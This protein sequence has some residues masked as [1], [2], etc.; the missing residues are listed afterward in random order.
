MRFKKGS[1]E[2][3]AFMAKL[4]NARKKKAA[5][6]KAVK[7]ATPKKAAPK[8]KPATKKAR[9]HKDTKSHNVRISVVS[10]IGSIKADLTRKLLN[11]QSHLAQLM[12]KLAETKQLATAT[13]SKSAK[14]SLPVIR[15]KIVEA[16]KVVLLLKKASK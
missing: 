3:K 15:K 13:K 14:A 9:T 2:A 1:K 8:R 16:K 5:P 10:G 11:A 7:K 6:K 4:R 12:G